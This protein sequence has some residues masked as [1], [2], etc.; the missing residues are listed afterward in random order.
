MAKQA[1]ADRLPAVVPVQQVN[2]RL[3]VKTVAMLKVWCTLNGVTQAATANACL[4]HQLETLLEQRPPAF[5]RAYR[6]AV[7]QAAA[8]AEADAEE[9]LDARDG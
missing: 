1:A 6:A 7:D 8:D 4:R 3:P 2:V 5:R 9:G